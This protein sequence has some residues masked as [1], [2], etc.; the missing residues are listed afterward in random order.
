MEAVACWLYILH[1][2]ACKSGGNGAVLLGAAA[3]GFF[4]QGAPLAAMATPIR[5][6]L[7]CLRLV[8]VP[9]VLATASLGVDWALGMAVLALFLVL[10]LD[11]LGWEMPGWI[12]PLLLWGS[13]F[14]VPDVGEV[15]GS[16]Y[17]TVPWSLGMVP[18]VA[19]SSYRMEVDRWRGVVLA[20]LFVIPCWV[21]SDFIFLNPTLRGTW[22]NY[23]LG[24]VLFV[25]SVMALL[26]VFRDIQSR[27]GGYDLLVQKD[28]LV[29]NGV[30]S[31]VVGVGLCLLEV[32]PFFLVA[33]F[34]LSLVGLSLVGM[35]QRVS[36]KHHHSLVP[37][38]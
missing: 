10:I 38:L 15:H 35:A 8:F 11:R 26:R 34:G 24:L 12:C 29:M 21:Q 3:V 28:L 18:L 30:Y 4:L 1:V 33:V 22:K 6:Y 37:S 27:Y 32:Q 36:L 16:D 31:A 25:N 9:M 14:V 20:A 17:Y 5:V 13:L 19:L 2:V 7:D 23:S